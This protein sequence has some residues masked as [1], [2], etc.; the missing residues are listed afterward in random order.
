[1]NPNTRVKLREELAALREKADDI[2]A[3]L[4]APENVPL[5]EQKWHFHDMSDNVWHIHRNHSK[6]REA[7]D[8]DDCVAIVY[9]DDIFAAFVNVGKL[10]KAATFAIAPLLGRGSVTAQLAVGDIKEA[11]KAMH[12]EDSE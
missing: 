11:L 3:R 8:D 4:D 10:I 1:M 6:D 7:N 12:V 5:T 2:E 9:G